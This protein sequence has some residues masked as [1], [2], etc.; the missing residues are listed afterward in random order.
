MKR[1]ITAVERWDTEQTNKNK[2]TAWKEKGE[3][4]EIFFLL[5]WFNPG[6]SVNIFLRLCL[7]Y[8]SR[9][10]FLWFLGEVFFV[11]SLPLKVTLLCGNIFYT[12]QSK[13]ICFF[14]YIF[15]IAII[16]NQEDAKI[17]WRGKKT[18]LVW[19]DLLFSRIFQIR[20]EIYCLYR[21]QAE[22]R[23]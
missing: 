11:S 23:I 22:N 2:R 6:V 8:R 16:N 5:N 7:A 15:T 4:G 9:R 20:L 19:C 12:C 10:E 14:L 3:R 1:T 18:T 13:W 21:E 17:I